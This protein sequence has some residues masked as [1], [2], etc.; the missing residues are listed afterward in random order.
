MLPKFPFANFLSAPSSPSVSPFQ[1]SHSFAE[2]FLLIG[3]T[4]PCGGRIKLNLIFTSYI[5]LESWIASES[6]LLHARRLH[7]VAIPDFDGAATVSSPR[8]VYD[9]VILDFSRKFSCFS[10]KRKM[11]FKN[12][13]KQQTPKTS[14][15]IGESAYGHT[16]YGF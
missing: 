2:A 11:Q 10:E 5:Y 13:A 4:N 12:R 7:P 16:F 9:C 15:E 3:W 6:F 14:G 1:W 8:C